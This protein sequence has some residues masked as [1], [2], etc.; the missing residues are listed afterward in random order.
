M[1]GILTHTKLTLCGLMM[2]LAVTAMAQNMNRYVT[3]N[4]KQGEQ[5]SIDLKAPTDDNVLARIVSGSTDVTVE[6]AYWTFHA[7]YYADADTMTIYG[8]ITGLDCEENGS[9]ITGLNAEHSDLLDYLDC[10]F[11][12]IESLA[13]NGCDKL[14]SLF[15]GN[16][17]I[18]ELNMDYFS[19][20]EELYC[21]NNN[22]GKL[23][24]KGCQRLKELVC[25]TNS[26]SDLVLHITTS[27]TV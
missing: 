10:S 24:L 5:I 11:C 8:D 25:N 1:K 6:V 27:F 16:N 21:N 9:K 7:D 15:C 3:L 2:L 19:K 20:L 14:L 23:E 4:V 12:E 22:L 26:L 13:V 18:T 17:K